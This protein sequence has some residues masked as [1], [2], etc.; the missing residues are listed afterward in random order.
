MFRVKKNVIIIKF[1]VKS[2]FDF[3]VFNFIAIAY[4]IVLN[5]NTFNIINITS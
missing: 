3:N 4:K 1:R 5:N 2:Y